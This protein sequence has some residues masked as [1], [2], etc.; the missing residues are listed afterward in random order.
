MT[1]AKMIEWVLRLG[2]GG[3]FVW[4]GIVKLQD[5]PAFL[6]AL[7]NYQLE[8]LQE[9]YDAVVAYTLPWIEIFSG[10]AVISGLGKSGGLVII[11]GMLG[12]FCWA[13]SVAW[14]KGLNI[15]CGCFSKSSEPV[16][17]PL[18]LA[19]NGGLILV[20]VILLLMAWRMRRIP[21]G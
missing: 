9:P 13:L 6:E 8:F 21:E 17:Y 5:L 20:A 12:S 15:N 2:L 16:N 11:M 4:S 19:E 10:L 7:G 14:S 18:K 1:K 3:L